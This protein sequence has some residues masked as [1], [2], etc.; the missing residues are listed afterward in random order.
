MNKPLTF[1]QAQHICSTYH[2]LEGT[3]YDQEFPGTTPI[4]A[5]MVAPYGE[6]AQQEFVDDFDILGYTDIKPY[7]E[8]D[9]Y[10]VIVL[11]RYLHDREICLWMDVRTFVSKNIKQVA[12]SRKLHLLSSRYDTGVAV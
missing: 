10:D 11:A 2:F 8:K 5:V 7:N 1:H 9:G 3:P 6:Q 12:S 4:Q